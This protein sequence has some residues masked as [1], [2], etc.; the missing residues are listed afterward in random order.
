M[1]LSSTSGINSFFLKKYHQQEQNKN[2]IYIGSLLVLLINSCCGNAIIEQDPLSFYKSWF[3]VVAH[4]K[5]FIKKLGRDIWRLV[6][7]NCKSNF[8]KWFFKNGCV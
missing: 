5:W 1:V 7:K 8:I 2:Y 6:S 4:K 3:L